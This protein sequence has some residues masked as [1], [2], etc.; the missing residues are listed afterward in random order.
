MHLLAVLLASNESL[1]RALS[2]SRLDLP[3]EVMRSAQLEGSHQLTI[4]AFNPA[5]RGDSFLDFLGEHVG[6][7]DNRP[8][9]SRFDGVVVLYESASSHRV[10]KIR[11]G[12]FAGEFDGS[13][14][15]EKQDNFLIR[16][17]GRLVKNLNSLMETMRDKT[18]LEAA[19][20][21]ERNFDSEV[22]RQFLQ[23]CE[24]QALDG[25]F[26]NRVVPALTAVTKLRGPKRR[27]K[28]PTRYFQDD[29]PACFQYGYEMHSMFETGGEHS[30]ACTI[31][32]LFRLGVPLEQQR[33]F[34]VTNIED[35]TRISGE[36][37]TCHEDCLAVSGRTHLN[38]F[39]N[40]FVK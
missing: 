34:N 6:I 1:I 8:A 21:P 13:S 38:M 18:R 31:R 10:S 26:P 12:V 20:L 35:G 32:G 15:I 24:E 2:Q 40:D 29:R 17:F 36:F 30:A 3:A 16:S 25:E 27:S 5:R 19:I 4:V 9:Q 28:Y 23:L 39:S 11:D 22:F 33:H 14:Y 7:V 37:R